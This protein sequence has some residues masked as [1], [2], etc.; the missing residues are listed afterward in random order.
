MARPSGDV[1]FDFLPFR[2][3]QRGEKDPIVR[4]SIRHCE[5]HKAYLM[6]D[7]MSS[8]RLSC[9]GNQ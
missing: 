9:L 5:T 2:E 4:P 7:L 1:Y 6:R 3:G 8:N